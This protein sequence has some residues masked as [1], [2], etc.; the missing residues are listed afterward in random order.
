MKPRESYLQ[1]LRGDGPQ[2]QFLRETATRGRLPRRHRS[3][4][5]STM[6]SLDDSG[7]RPGSGARREET[8]EALLRRLGSSAEG[9]SGVEA[10]H[11]LEE[12]GPNELT[13][14]GLR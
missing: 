14:I 6:G 2:T 9:L 4:A 5:S 7:S 10:A 3:R 8:V 11:R 1:S 12:C 13:S